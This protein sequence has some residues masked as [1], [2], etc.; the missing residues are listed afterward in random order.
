MK[1]IFMGTPEYGVPVL[2]GILRSRHKVVAVV[3]QPDRPA[4]RNVIMKPPVKLLAEERGIKVLQYNR[5]SREG[6]DE[7]KALNADI[8][9]TAAFG[10][11]LSEEVLNIAPYGVINVHASI[12]PHYRGSAP[13]HYAIINGEKTTGVTIMQTAKS[14]DSGD[15]IMQRT[16]DIKEG[17]TAGELTARLAI[18][19]AEMI[20]NALDDIESGKAVKI[21]QEHNRATYFPMLKKTDGRIDFARTPYEIVNFVR[22]M[23]PWPGAFFQINGNTVKIIKAEINNENYAGKT[24]EIVESNPKTGL[25]IKAKDG[26]VNILQVQPQGKKV[27]AAKDYLM[28]NP[29]AKGSIVC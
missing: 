24:G 4:N 20:V 5:I 23:Q 17:E 18:L 26:C 28:G 29:V 6:V 22:G 8:M 3:C 25:V 1:V 13:V 9:V 14:V 11:I 2:E 12:L 27:M 16:I 10:Q 19:G 7:L 21:P 15:I